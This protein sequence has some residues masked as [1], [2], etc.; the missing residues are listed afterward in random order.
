L[1]E[2]VGELELHLEAPNL[3]ALFEEAARALARVMAEDF[4][5][6]TS[7]PVHVELLASDRASLLVDWLN[8]LVYRTDVDK[9]VYGEV[10]VEQA[11]ERHLSASL[12]GRSPTAPRTA[13]KAATWHRLA[14][15][16][17]PSGLEA[18]VVLD[19]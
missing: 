10:H 6:A 2:H 12:R 1:V 11:D 16:E 15:R 19:V 13:V 8:E 18:T 17:T 4:E 5:P 3:A 7:T 9:R 14:V